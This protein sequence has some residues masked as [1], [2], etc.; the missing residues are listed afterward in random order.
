MA[1]G[2]RDIVLGT[3]LFELHEKLNLEI[4]QIRTVYIDLQ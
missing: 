2:R 4:S 3:A 1:E